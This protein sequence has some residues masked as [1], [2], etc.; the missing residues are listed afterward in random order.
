MLNEPLYNS[1]LAI[2]N[3]PMQLNTKTYAVVFL[4]NAIHNRIKTKC[5]PTNTI[6]A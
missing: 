4:G 2:T 6:E 1:F 5:Y 3:S